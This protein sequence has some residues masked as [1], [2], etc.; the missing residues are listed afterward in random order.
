MNVTYISHSGFAVELPSVSL[1][2]DYYKGNLPAFSP[3]K[4]LFVFASHG[5]RDHFNP[6][7]FRLAQR[8][9]QTQFLLSHDV[10]ASRRKFL[11]AGA[12][13]EAFDAAVFLRAHE[14]RDFSCPS[15]ALTVS[16]LRSTDLGV[17]FLVRCDGL[18]VYHAGDL[19]WWLWKGDSK[20]E[21]GNMAANFR[22][23]MQALCHESLD[24]AFVP[25][26]PRQEEYYSL[27]VNYLLEHTRV[28]RLFP[29]HFW[30]DY[31]VMPRYLA[32]FPQMAKR[33]QFYTIA[34]EGQSWEL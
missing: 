15:G 34:R 23:E 5:H 21:A 27:G 16:T 10:K 30:D 18:T 2:F 11:R 28:R 29:M 17:A 31:T 14:T 13:E 33:T 12:A 1:L 19:N 25:L 6:D 24:L 3:A 4:P 32:E 7:I 8:C 26:D 9:P 20:Q 22:R